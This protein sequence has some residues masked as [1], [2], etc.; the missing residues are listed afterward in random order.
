[1]IGAGALLEAGKASEALNGLEAI[2]KENPNHAEAHYW[3][4]RALDELSRPAEA[5]AHYAAMTKVLKDADCEPP[6]L[7]EAPEKVGSE[8][9]EA[10]GTR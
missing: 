4:G 2:L 3:C 7:K 6:W 9:L 1:V 10:K 8:A 5:Q